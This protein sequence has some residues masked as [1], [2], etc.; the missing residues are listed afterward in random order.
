MGRKVGERIY[1]RVLPDVAHYGGRI[2]EERGDDIMLETYADSLSDLSKGRCIVISEDTGNCYAE[3]VD[4]ER[5]ILSLKRLWDEKRESFRVDDVFPLLYSKVDRDMPLR[6]S[7]FL[8]AWF[9]ETPEGNEPDRTVTP[10]LWK[11]LTTLNSK[12]NLILER[13]HLGDEG[14]LKAENRQVNMSA[15]GMRFR[16]K[17]KID[18][19]DILE[20]KL[21]LPPAMPLLIHGKVVRMSES[22]DGDY[23]VALHFIDVDDE[24]QDR[25]V[26]YA[27]NRQREIAKKQTECRV[28]DA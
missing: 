4:R 14:L 26:Y 12:L 3:V 5:N 2:L 18:I 28:P 13:L 8:A 21:L 25:I 1:Y 11:M 23:N 9:P 7:G 6:R 22:A 19:G 24:I 20:V 17:E 16:V 15:S 10:A 27:L